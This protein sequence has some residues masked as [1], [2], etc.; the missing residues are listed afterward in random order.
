MRSL[1]GLSGDGCALG[2]AQP[3]PQ[4]RAALLYPLHHGPQ[5]H[6]DYEYQHARCEI[7][8]IQTQSNCEGVVKSSQVKLHPG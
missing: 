8:Y 4:P 1:D 5:P 2:V 6:Q 3:G 7:N